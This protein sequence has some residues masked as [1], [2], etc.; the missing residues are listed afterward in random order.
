MLAS[1]P[2]PLRAEVSAREAACI[3]GARRALDLQEGSKSLC[4][5]AG[6]T[7]CKT[8]VPSSAAKEEVAKSSCMALLTYSWALMPPE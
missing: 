1:R 7:K 8:G 2:D 4:V 3:G 5:H 6:S